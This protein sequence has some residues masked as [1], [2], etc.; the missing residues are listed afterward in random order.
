MTATS[1]PGEGGKLSADRTT[2]LLDE[3]STVVVAADVSDRQWLASAVEAFEALKR[4]IGSDC[5]EDTAHALEGLDTTL[6][7]L[8]RESA[9]NPD[10]DVTTVIEALDLLQSTL[11][12]KPKPV[13]AGSDDSASE[14]SR[15][16][17]RRLVLPAEV[18]DQIFGEFLGNL[19]LTLPEFTALVMGM[20]D[21]YDGNVNELR[22]RVHTLKGEAG[23]LE[24]ADLERVC[25]A[26][27]S[28]LE[29]KLSISTKGGRLIGVCDWM[30][31][32]LDQYAQRQLPVR[33]GAS[34]VAD[35]LDDDP[36]QSTFSCEPATE[37]LALETSPLAPGTA[38]SKPE[39]LPAPPPP[40]AAEI[41]LAEAANVPK[42]WDP[43]EIEL[44][45]EFL[46]ES[47][48]GLSTVDQTLLTMEHSG[49][50]PEQIHKMFRV[51]HTIKGVSSFLDLAQV[52]D[53]S[54]ATENTLDRV[55]SGTLT[56]D[57]EVAD[58]VFDATTATRAL[59]TDLRQAIHQGREVHYVPD[60]NA[61]LTRLSEVG[62]G[63]LK[64][65]QPAS[66]PRVEPD[67]PVGEILVEEGLITSKDLGE[68]L[69]SQ[70]RSGRKTG[71][72]LVARGSIPAK[73]MAQVLRAQNQA[74]GQPAAK[75]REVVKVDLERV[76]SLVEA[77]GEL[78][79]VESMVSHAPEIR[80]L[81]PHLHTY[82]GQLAKITRELQEIGMRMRMVPLRAVFQ[83]TNRM[84]RDLA[85][86]ANKQ[87]AIEISG[88]GT[89]MDR[90]MVDQIGD[91]LVHLIRNAMDHGL[92]PP[93][94]RIARGKSPEGKV[95]LS[96]AH[97]GGSIVIAISD[98]GRGIDRQ[99]VL[100]KAIDKGLV[101]QGA[102]MSDA[103]VF[104]LIF[105]PG[106]STAKSVT[107]ISG[108]GV[109]MDVVRRNVEAMRGRVVVS[110][111]PGCGTT[112]R[113]V[114]PLTL[115]IID[116]MVVRCGSES[117]IVPTLAIV[118]SLKPTR[119]MLA[120]M[121]GRCEIVVVRDEPLPL[122]RLDDFLEIRGAVRDPAQALVVIVESLGRKIAILADEVV[123][124]QQVVIKSMGWG[125]EGTNV[126]SGAAIL[127]DGRVGLII[128]VDELAI[129]AA[130]IQGSSHNPSARPTRG[131]TAAS[132]ACPA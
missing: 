92:E 84:V 9:S 118:E 71:E 4:E 69:V 12:S 37:T 41:G 24:L 10:D 107:E 132:S 13:G 114:L 88:E 15:A 108:R 42:A 110:S 68:A 25:H 47:E 34:V 59:L 32:A 7:G 97:Q 112:F 6:A 61:L 36:D 126:F 23:A 87:V 127:S 117:F 31:Q 121:A 14:M 18:D 60:L 128:N 105:S 62:R 21:G 81:P 16:T 45:V 124:Q 8:S 63:G 43:S 26:V 75:I 123:T 70:R 94:E 89:E 103:E 93:E 49:K 99:A 129:C 104:D 11:T 2:E 78:V 22:R 48:D 17:E 64:Q 119:D 101:R 125:F 66:L 72:E 46:D 51:F 38:E 74:R 57:D 65:V 20:Q 28:L 116:G 39:P 27:E 109:G 82:L 50:D 67:Q 29:S 83:K 76:D 130:E 102:V 44:V 80:E 115:A 100:N 73:Q 120:T 85:R 19:K 95:T 77:I 122:L 40:P 111:A 53:L 56:F 1:G 113:M 35:L 3:L 55:R 5:P 54:H 106:F 33:D 90:S 58:L 86:K 131:A 30:E 91:P 52:T 98:D 79:I 96:A